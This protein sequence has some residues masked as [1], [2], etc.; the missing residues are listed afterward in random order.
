DFRESNTS[1]RSP[2]DV[3]AL[4]CE[5]EH[6]AHDSVLTPNGARLRLLAPGRYRSLNLA[7][8]HSTDRPRAKPRADVHSHN[9]F[10]AGERSRTL[11][12]VARQPLTCDVCDTT[13]S[14][15]GIEPVPAA[16]V[17]ELSRLEHRCFASRRELLLEVAPVGVP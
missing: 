6:G 9:A 7:S 3:V 5:C 2:R 11:R 1:A 14:I 10:I 12:G 17:G 16:A 4:H 13:L 8:S 15:A